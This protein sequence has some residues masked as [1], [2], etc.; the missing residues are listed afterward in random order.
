MGRRARAPLVHAQ[1]RL[2]PELVRRGGLWRVAAVSS[3][4]LSTVGRMRRSPRVLALVLALLAITSLFAL[5]PSQARAAGLMGVARQL[6][7]TYRAVA[8]RSAA[9]VS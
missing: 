1:G 5:A 4:P 6:A 9:R 2:N 8:R 7:N 3:C